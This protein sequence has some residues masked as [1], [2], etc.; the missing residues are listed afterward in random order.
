MF[1]KIK[2]NQILKKYFDG[3]SVVLYV[4][5]VAALS[6][7]WS[8]IKIIDKNYQLEKNISRLQQE[9]DILDQQTKNQKLKNEYYKTDAFLELAAR[10][11]FGRAAPGEKLL[12]ISKDAANKY[13]HLSPETGQNQ[14]QTKSRPQFIKNWQAWI[15]FFTHKQQTT[16]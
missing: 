11:Y 5:A 9:V 3:R 13:I 2:N 12:L 4:L 10:K 1:E 7:T 15:N 14:S 8:S 6:V 16:D